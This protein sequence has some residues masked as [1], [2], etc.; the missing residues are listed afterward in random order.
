[1][2]TAG[3]SNTIYWCPDCTKSLSECRTGIS[4]IPCHILKKLVVK[5]ELYYQIL[6][7]NISL[8]PDDVQ[9]YV[10]NKMWSLKYANNQDKSFDVITMAITYII[11]TD[12]NGKHNTTIDEMFELADSTYG[13]S[14]LANE[15]EFMR[16]RIDGYEKSKRV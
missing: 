9:T 4:R 10:R 11:Y 14:F 8:C 2:N 1:M 5:V 15:I 12:Y 3:N 13:V 7:K 16:R 6:W